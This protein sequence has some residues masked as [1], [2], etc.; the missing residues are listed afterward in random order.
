M[1]VTICNPTVDNQWKEQAV[2]GSAQFPAAFYNDDL[3][4]E[5]VP[6]HWH[7][8]LEFIVGTD[9]SET[10]TVGKETF[11]LAEGEGLFIN[12]GELHA[13]KSCSGQEMCRIRSV[14]FH[15]RLVGGLD[16]I[17]WSRYVKP[18]LDNSALHYYLFTS[19]DAEQAVLISGFLGAWQAAADDAPGY[20][21]QVR[22]VLSKLVF[23]LDAA[24][25]AA[26]RRPSGREQ[27]NAARIKE[28]LQFI[29]CHYAESLSV[30][31]IAESCRISESECLRCFRSTIGTT[32][33]RYLLQYRI[34]KAAELLLSSGQSAGDIGALCGFPDNSYF[35]KMFREEKG[36]TPGEFRK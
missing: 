25:P 28:M 12:H 19:A 18:L 15:P 27:R 4:R 34:Q 29:Q 32:P 17:L 30:S 33:N 23:Y 20:E 22:E 11:Q 31:L 16:S 21:F 8:E 35:T 10:V 9:G 3:R 24:A 2:H 14:V 26:V 36:C 1:A 6:W 5:T 13:L 7:E